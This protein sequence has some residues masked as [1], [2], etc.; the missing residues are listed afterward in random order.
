M[1]KAKEMNNSLTIRLQTR[2]SG[3]RLFF[4]IDVFKYFAEVIG[5]QL[6]LQV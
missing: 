3:L 1:I 4:K 5:K 6:C 2:G